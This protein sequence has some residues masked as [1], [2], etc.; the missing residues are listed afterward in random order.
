MIKKE[1]YM[2]KQEVDRMLSQAAHWVGYLEKS[3]RDLSAY[4]SFT[5]RAGRA[6][7]TRFGRIADIVIG[8]ADRRVKDGYAWCCMFVLAVLYEMKAGKQDCSVPS[9][10][11]IVDAE[12]RKWVA[13]TVN[14]GRPVTYFAGCQAWLSAYKRQGRVAHN[15]T[16][17]DFVIYTRDAVYPNDNGYPYHIGIVESVEADGKTFVTIEGNTSAIGNNIEPNGGCVARKIRKA[18]ERTLF[19]QNLLSLQR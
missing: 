16:R 15:P 10:K 9:G 12:A 5:D 3:A 4:E 19:L 14:G 2:T 13:D 18:G 11:M 7:W 6:N 17:G 8:G 1:R